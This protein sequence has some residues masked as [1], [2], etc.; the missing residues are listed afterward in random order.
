MQTEFKAH[1][2]YEGKEPN[3]L[4]KYF[5]EDIFVQIYNEWCEM[6]DYESWNKEYEASGGEFDGIDENGAI[7]PDSEYVRF[8]RTKQQAITDQILNPMLNKNILENNG[9]SRFRRFFVG[10]ECDFRAELDDGTKMWFYL[11]EA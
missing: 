5:L 3:W 11:K 9:Q 7:I 6:M 1:F 2:K 4:E 10:E 8:I